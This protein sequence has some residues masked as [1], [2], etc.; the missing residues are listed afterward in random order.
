MNR[1]QKKV[2]ALAGAIANLSLSCAVAGVA[3]YAWFT[4]T[5]RANSTNISMSTTTKHIDLDYV[6]LKY[7]DE[8]KQG[9]A[10]G[11]SDP[12][13]FVLPE[14]DQYIKE[15]NKYCNIIVRANLVFAEPVDTS[16]TEIKIDITKLEGSPVFVV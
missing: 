2:L 8:L 3:T 10:G 1:C 16:K 11:L 7:D 12:T 5:A 14:Y 6:I 9:V 15:R 13:E 4:S